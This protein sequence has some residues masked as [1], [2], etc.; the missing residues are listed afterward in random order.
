MRDED[1]DYSAEPT[2][3]KIHC[4]QGCASTTCCARN[5]AACCRRYRVVPLSRPRHVSSLVTREKKNS[6]NSELRKC[7]CIGHRGGLWP[8]STKPQRVVVCAGV[9]MRYGCIYTGCIFGLSTIYNL[10]PCIYLYIYII[11]L[12]QAQAGTRRLATCNCTAPEARADAACN[13]QL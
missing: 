8:D 3:R 13:T 5:P 10:H 11:D 7:Y 1:T 12:H 9:G 4:V 6:E 2:P